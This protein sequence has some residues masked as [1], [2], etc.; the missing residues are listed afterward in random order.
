MSKE[1]IKAR[2]IEIENY[3]N[4]NWQGLS[5][6]FVERLCARA[7]YDKLLINLK[8]KQNV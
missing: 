2:L 7:E 1:Y 8:E 6:N 3:L 4:K 5:D